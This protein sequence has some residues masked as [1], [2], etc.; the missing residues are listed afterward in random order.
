MGI[1]RGKEGGEV[2]F[3]SIT[4]EA[5]EGSEGRGH[6]CSNVILSVALGDKD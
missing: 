1:G 4:S 3:S 5:F 6:K 2:A